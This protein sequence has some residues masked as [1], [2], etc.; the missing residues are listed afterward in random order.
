M[1]RLDLDNL[2]EFGS[3]GRPFLEACGKTWRELVMTEED[4]VIR[5]RMR[6][7]LRLAHVLEGADDVALTA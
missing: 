5:R 1:C 4:L 2:D 7:P 3:M 6:A